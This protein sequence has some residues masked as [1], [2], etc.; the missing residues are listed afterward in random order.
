MDSDWPLG[1]LI[2]WL[3]WGQHGFDVLLAFAFLYLL[4]TV[5]DL[6]KCTEDRRTRIAGRA[7]FVAGLA[8]FLILMKWVAYH[9]P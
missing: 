6:E 9:E 4:G 8:A 1:Q 5:G 2:R 7:K 3:S